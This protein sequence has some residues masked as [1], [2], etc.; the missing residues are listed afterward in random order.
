MQQSAEFEGVGWANASLRGADAA[1][2]YSDVSPAAIV[3]PF[4]RS[5]AVAAL[6]AVS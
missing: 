6:Q 5:A 1:K 3:G 2:I 4:Q